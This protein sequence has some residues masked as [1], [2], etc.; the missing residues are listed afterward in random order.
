MSDPADEIEQR[1][2]RGEWLRPGEVALLLEVA[3]STVHNWL[4]RGRLRYR[5]RPVSGYRECHPEDVQ[6]MLA[7]YRQQH[8][9]ADA[10]PPDTTPPTDQPVTDE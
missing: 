6:Q 9:A 10:G 8:P 4:T 2:N 5:Q 3:R 1:L 7:Q